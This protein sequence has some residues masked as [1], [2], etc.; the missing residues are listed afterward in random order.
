MRHRRADEA[1]ANEVGTNE[2]KANETKTPGQPTEAKTN[3]TKTNETNTV[4]AHSDEAPTDN[5]ATDEGRRAD[6]TAIAAHEADHARLDTGGGTAAA[7]EMTTPAIAPDD[8]AEPSPE[9]IDPPPIAAAVQLA[10]ES[11][12][13]SVQVVAASL[14]PELDLVP[15]AAPPPLSSAPAA[16]IVEQPPDM[17]AMLG[18]VVEPLPH[19]DATAAGAAS[20]MPPLTVVELELEPADAPETSRFVAALP[21]HTSTEVAHAIAIPSPAAS[22]L[23]SCMETHEGSEAAAPAG[24]V[25]MGAAVATPELPVA[26]PTTQPSMPAADPL[27]ALRAMSEAERIA[28]FS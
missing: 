10:A 11:D 22:R 25:T 27:A 26:T 16:V 13:A 8:A 15:L 19:V 5:A 28:M 12:R 1:R 14:L 23:Q 7:G 17:Q 2:I 24:A 21:D 6:E 20:T 18:I 4:E 3:E 9:E